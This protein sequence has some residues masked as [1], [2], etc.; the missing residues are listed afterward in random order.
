MEPISFHWRVLSHMA[1]PK[2]KE[3]WKE[4]RSPGRRGNKFSST[5]VS[6][7]HNSLYVQMQMNKTES[8]LKK[9]QQGPCLGSFWTLMVIVQE[10]HESRV[11]WLHSN[12]A[13]IIY[14]QC[15]VVIHIFLNKRKI[16]NLFMWHIAR[17]IHIHH[18]ISS[19]QQSCEMFWLC[20]SH[21]LQIRKWALESRGAHREW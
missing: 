21:I 12:L 15:I 16:K 6:L 13:S 4:G 19:S 18:F 7:C 20:L 1:S 14:T 8:S 17:S 11:T 2:C 10:P 3:T 5:S 9:I